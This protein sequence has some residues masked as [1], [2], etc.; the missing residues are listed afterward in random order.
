M[1]NKHFHLDRVKRYL[2]EVFSKERHLTTYSKCARDIYKV[3]SY[4]EWVNVR[5]V[6]SWL[7][8]GKIRIESDPQKITAYAKEFA[9]NISSLTQGKDRTEKD[10]YLWALATAIWVYGGMGNINPEYRGNKR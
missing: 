8:D 6:E 2:D 9:V 7:K 3:F 5:D 10:V 1:Q 4:L